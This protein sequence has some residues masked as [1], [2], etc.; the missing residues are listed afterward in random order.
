MIGSAL[1]IA[2]AIFSLWVWWV[3]NRA[4][5]RREKIDEEIERRNQLRKE[6]IDSWVDTIRGD[7]WWHRR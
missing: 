6:R 1:A 4:K 2:G 7:S 5:T 3:K